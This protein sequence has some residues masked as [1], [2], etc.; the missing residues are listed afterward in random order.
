MD[1]SKQQFELN[2]ETDQNLQKY[3]RADSDGE[4][5]N[6][7]LY[8]GDGEDNLMKRFNETETFL[9]KVTDI[10]ISIITAR[11]IVEINKSMLGNA[12]INFFYFN[13]QQDN[14]QKN[15]TLNVNCDATTKLSGL[16]SIDTLTINA[17]E[18][19]CN[20]T[21]FNELNINLVDSPKHI[22]KNKMIGKASVNRIISPS[23]PKI[24]LNQIMK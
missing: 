3:F 16:T 1:P 24:L 10:R 9:F 5:L 17:D 18:T 11:P 8:T 23:K 20:N 13:D 2:I 14:Q 19:V 12:D 22:E 6:V 7:S 21:P 4:Y 15:M